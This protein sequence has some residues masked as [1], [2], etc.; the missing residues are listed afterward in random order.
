MDLDAVGMPSRMK[1]L[2]RSTVPLVFLDS[3]CGSGPWPS[4]LSRSAPTQ[5]ASDLYTLLLKGFAV[6][7]A[8]HLLAPDN[9]RTHGAGRRL[10]VPPLR[11]ALH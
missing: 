6:V 3:G 4:R 11:C 7:A 8:Y 1:H 9:S 5:I 10:A 2:P